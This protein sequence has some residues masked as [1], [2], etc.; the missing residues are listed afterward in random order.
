MNKA[1]HCHLLWSE[2]AVMLGQLCNSWT[3]VD[4]ADHRLPGCTTG[5][6]ITSSWRAR[7]GLYSIIRKSDCCTPHAEN[8]KCPILSRFASSRN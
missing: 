5:S 3:D 7:V 6:N 1:R 2:L 8:P 4:T